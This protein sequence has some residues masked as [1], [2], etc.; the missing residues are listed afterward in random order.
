MEPTKLVKGKKYLL[1]IKKGAEMTAT[2]VQE[3]LNYREFH[4]ENGGKIYLDEGA[5]KNDV[6][7]IDP[8]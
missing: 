4:T 3:T 6:K 2:Y 8:C 7:E 1:G 5:A